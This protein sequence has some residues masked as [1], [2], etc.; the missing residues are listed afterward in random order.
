M[1]PVAE[2]RTP[3]L[4]DKRDLLA[5]EKFSVCAG[6][7]KKNQVITDLIDEEKISA[8]MALAMAGPIVT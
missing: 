5:F 3:D 6:S 8:D 4:R 2:P 7:N 1:C